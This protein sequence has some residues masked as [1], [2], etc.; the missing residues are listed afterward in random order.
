MCV[1]KIITAK[2]VI[3]VCIILV[4]VTF[5]SA[6]NRSSNPR[7]CRRAFAGDGKEGT[8][9]P[10]Q[11]IRPDVFQG[12]KRDANELRK[13]LGVSVPVIFYE[14]AG[15]PDA[16]ANFPL[17]DKIGNK[18]GITKE[19][20]KDGAVFIGVKLLSMEFNSYNGTGYST[21]SIL[22]HEFAHILQYRDL[23]YNE[24]YSEIEGELHADFIAG[25]Y[26]GHRSR[27]TPQDIIESM[28]SFYRHGGGSHGTP[29]DRL[30]AFKA[31]LHLNL[32]LCVSSSK[33]A[34][35][36]GLSYIK[37]RRSRG[38]SR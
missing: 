3:S 10:I 37:A 29:E 31:G 16:H 35:D 17:A 14:E 23:D 9:I 6:Q 13:I 18:Y 36:A 25:W 33:L 32:C 26:T 21:P 15:D 5:V 2:Q 4:I 7:G 34:Y 24:K 22:A 20:S 27:Y 8:I 11:Q 1:S 19:E 30:D 12:I 28:W 38:Q